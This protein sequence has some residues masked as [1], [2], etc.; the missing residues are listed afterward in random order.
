MRSNSKMLMIAM[1]NLNYMYAN[2]IN[3]EKENLVA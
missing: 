1:R 2:K 3:R